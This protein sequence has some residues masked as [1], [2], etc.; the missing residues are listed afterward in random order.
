M[1]YFLCRKSVGLI[2]NMVGKVFMEGNLIV[3]LFG[4]SLKIVI[5]LMISDGGREVCEDC[6]WKVYVL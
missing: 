1:C 5:G 4:S 2:V 6:V 3:I